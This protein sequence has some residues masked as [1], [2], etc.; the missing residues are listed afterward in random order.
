LKSNTSGGSSSTKVEGVDFINMYG[1][2][3]T[4]EYLNEHPDIQ[5]FLSVPQYSDPA[6]AA[7]S[8][9]AHKASG[10]A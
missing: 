4:A 8:D 7:G 3:S 1:D 5:A 6:D 2:V 9:L 10:T